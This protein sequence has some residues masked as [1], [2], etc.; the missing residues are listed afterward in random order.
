MIIEILQFFGITPDKLGPIVVVMGL[1]FYFLFKYFLKPIKK[2]IKRIDL[3]LTNVNNA[4]VE[5]QSCLKPYFKQNRREIIHPLTIKPGSPWVLTEYGEDLVEKSGFLKILKE[6]RDIIVNAVKARNPQTN[7]DIQK[8]SK[9]IL[10][11]DFIN[12]SMMKPVK[13][14]AF[15]K[16]MSVETILEPAGLLVRDEVMKE[17]KFD[18][19]IN[20][21]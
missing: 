3:D 17:I 7:Y 20:A 5:I 12:D 11:K 10:L 21:Q 4:V 13:N 9:D 14:Y 19:N 16:N 6:N 15:E 2:S 8:F 1:T 18:K